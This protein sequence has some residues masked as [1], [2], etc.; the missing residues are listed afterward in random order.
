MNPLN[1]SD[2]SPY[3][4]RLHSAIG[5]DEVIFRVLTSPHSISVRE[6][7][8]CTNRGTWVSDMGDVGWAVVAAAVVA[9]VA[10]RHTSHLH[11]PGDDPRAVALLAKQPLAGVVP[12]VVG[13]GKR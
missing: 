8:S 1:V 10:A 3:R 9:V 12:V 13:G 4:T 6:E 5:S 11:E 7:L 2:G